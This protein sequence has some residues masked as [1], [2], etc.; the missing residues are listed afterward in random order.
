MFYRII[1]YSSV[2]FLILG[3]C[4]RAPIVSPPKEIAPPVRAEPGI[5]HKV[6]KGETLWRISKIYGVE[7]EK[8]VAANRISNAERIMTGQEIFIPRAT[9]PIETKLSPSGAYIKEDFVWP[10]KGK[11]VLY[12]GEQRGTS[13]NKGIDIKARE[14]TEVIASRSGKVIFTDD[15]VKGYGKTVILDH[16]DELQTLYAHNSEIL[17]KIGD[18][19]RQFTSI[20]KVGSTG[21]AKA[22]YLHFEIRKRHQPQNPL[23]YLP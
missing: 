4:A 21:R 6:A 17:V 22:P 10:V 18:D 5:Y 7:L 8:V 15:K 13:A 12:F 2:L 14:G 23:H 3:G 19:V 16:G 20:A 1:I 11:V 9:K